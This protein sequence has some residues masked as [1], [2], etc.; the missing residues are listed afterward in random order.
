MQVV[1]VEVRVVMSVHV[2]VHQ[3]QHPG[4][5]AG[6]RGQ[7]SKWPQVWLNVL[8]RRVLRVHGG[9]CLGVAVPHTRGPEQGGGAEAGQGLLV[10]DTGG[11]AGHLAPRPGGEDWG[12][13][14]WSGSCNILTPLQI[15]KSIDDEL[16]F[17]GNASPLILLSAFVSGAPTPESFEPLSEWIKIW[18]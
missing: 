3:P 10:P 16:M 5:G 13:R 9:L 4:V 17:T 18:F 7:T 15:N 2:G 8:H 12:N 1:Y 11:G 14:C 6:H